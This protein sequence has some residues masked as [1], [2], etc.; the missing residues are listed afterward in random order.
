MGLDKDELPGLVK[1]WRDA[2]PKIVKF[3][4]ST[5]AAVIKAIEERTTVKNY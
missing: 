3:W 2:N 1:Q 4:Y 5:E